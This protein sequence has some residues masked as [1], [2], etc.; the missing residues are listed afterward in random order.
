MHLAMDKVEVVIKG[1]HLAR[2]E[3]SP[4]LKWLMVIIMT[5]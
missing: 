5:L 1:V 4:D 3:P 2:W